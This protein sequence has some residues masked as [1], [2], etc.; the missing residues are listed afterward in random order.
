M[1]LQAQAVRLQISDTEC[2]RENIEA[3]QSQVT[4]T[5]VSDDLHGQPVYF[6]V[7]VR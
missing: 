4:L 5:L 2:F 1:L 6:D 3:E 7:M